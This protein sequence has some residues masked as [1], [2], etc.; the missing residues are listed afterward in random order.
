MISILLAALALS[1]PAEPPPETLLKLTVDATAAPKPAL[2]YLLLPELRE[3]TPGNPIPNY[4]KAVL[5]RESGGIDA[6][7]DKNALQQVDRAARMDKPDWQLLDKLRADGIGLL[8][9]DLQKMR[10]LAQGLHARFRDEI[11]Q[12]RFDDAVV[13]AKTM[14][15]LSKHVGEHPTIIGQLV[16]IAI[17]NVAIQPLEEMIGQPDAP[18]FYWALAHLPVPFIALDRGIEGERLIAGSVSLGLDDQKPMTTAQLKAA[19]KMINGLTGDGPNDRRGQERLSGLAQDDAYM[20]GARK[21]L[22]ET[23]IPA[24]RLATFS[25]YQ[26]I[27]LNERIE[28]EIQRDELMKLSPLPTWEAISRMDEAERKAAKATLFSGLLPSMHM[29]RRAQG[30][31]EQRIALLRHV[32]AIRLYAATHGGKVP[33]KLSEIDVPLPIDPFTGKPFRYEVIG[34][35]AHLRGIPPKGDEKNAAYNLHYEVIIRK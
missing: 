16:A 26:V 20:A 28:F 19:I 10:E 25:N 2:K 22:T 18:N 24:D 35:V 15:A 32:E 33:A 8:L 23:G 11:A 31:L 14:F 7:L 34:G 9:P 30:R 5:D 21:R 3:Q 12:R 4:M 13:T 17:A 1:Q 27:L 29:V 6:P